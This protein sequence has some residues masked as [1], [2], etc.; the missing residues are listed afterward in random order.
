MVSLNL[1]TKLGEWD[2]DEQVMEESSSILKVS[3]VLGV[4]GCGV[5]V[6]VAGESLVD[7]RFR[8]GEVDPS[9]RGMGRPLRVFL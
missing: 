3:G 8:E 1:R 9:P 6:R 2:A 7:E 5:G 4:V